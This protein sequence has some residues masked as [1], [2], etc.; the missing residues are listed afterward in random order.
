[1]TFESIYFIELDDCKVRLQNI[2]ALIL[3]I[4]RYALSSW[5]LRNFGDIYWWNWNIKTWKLAEA[6]LIDIYTLL[7][8]YKSGIEL[9]PLLFSL[10]RV[11]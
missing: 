5:T 9:D 1:M 6:C 3:N 2:D 4:D 11:S 8:F 10:G 7:I